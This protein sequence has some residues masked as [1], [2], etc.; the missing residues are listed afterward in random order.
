MFPTPVNFFEKSCVSIIDMSCGGKHTLFLSSK[1]FA[2]N[3]LD[4]GNVYG[5]G[6]NDYGQIG[7]STE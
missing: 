7:I 5:C 2:N 3:L 1:Y 4:N 6:T